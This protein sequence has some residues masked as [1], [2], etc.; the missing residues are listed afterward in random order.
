ML[1]LCVFAYFFPVLVLYKYSCFVL[2]YSL[3]TSVS[4]TG[5]GAVRVF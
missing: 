3:W 4:T 2:V 1:L 5:A